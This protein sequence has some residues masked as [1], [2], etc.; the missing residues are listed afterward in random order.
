[1]EPFVGEIRPF[2][3]NRIP[4]G[5]AACNGQ[6]LS[7]QGNQ[8]LFALLGTTY[9]GNGTTNFALPDLRGAVPMHSDGQSVRLGS[10]AGEERHVLTVNEMPSHTHQINASANN[11][12]AVSPAGNVWAVTND[13]NVYSDP[14]N[15][16]A[17]YPAA[18]TSAGGSEA[19]NNMQPYMVINYCI[20]LVGIFPPRN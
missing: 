3:F 11:A 8:A 6:L 7:I 20:A 12:S 16:Q 2:A 4:R 9:G 13:K 19:H 1:M 18:L 17:M 14:N 5:W 15:I 10:R